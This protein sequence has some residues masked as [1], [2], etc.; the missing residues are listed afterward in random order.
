MQSTN[1]FGPS[2]LDGRPAGDARAAMC[3]L[4]EDCPKCGFV[5][6]SLSQKIAAA[7]QVMLSDEFQKL[8]LEGRKS[9][10]RFLRGGLIAVADEKFLQ[11]SYYFL[12]AAWTS[13]DKGDVDGAKEARLRFIDYSLQVLSQLQNAYEMSKRR[14]MFEV[15]MSRARSNKELEYEVRNRVIDCLRRIGNFSDAVALI[16]DW[17]H[18]ALL[19]DQRRL[20]DCQRYLCSIGDSGVYVRDDPRLEGNF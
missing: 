15:H 12:C 10:S 8:L 18:K 17:N 13:D 19:P 6:E 3:S 2:D 20:R 16:S 14:G 5:S 7:E 11:A 1:S 9:F 4:V